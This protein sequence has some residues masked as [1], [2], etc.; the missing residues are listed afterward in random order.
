MKAIIDLI[1]YYK[2][3]YVTILY[4]E[5]TGIERIEDLV[6]MQREY[7]QQ[8]YSSNPYGQ[9]QPN[10][11]RIQVRQ[12]SK[13]VDK[14]IYLIKDVKLGSSSHI[15][16]DIQT[17]YLNDFLKQAEEVGLMTAYFH[18]IFTSL[19]IAILEHAP[20]ANI[21]A[22]QI[23]E[24]NDQNVKSLFA[25]F[26]LKNMVAHKPMFKYMPSEAVFIYDAFSLIANTIDRQNLAEVIPS[27]PSVSCAKEQPW[28]FGTDFLRSMKLSNFNGLSGHIE[29]DLVKGYRK[30]ITL[31]IVDKTKAGVDLIGYWRG[32]TEKGTIQIVRSYA[33]EKDRILDK[34]NRHLNVTTKLEAPY[35]MYKEPVNNETLVGNDRFKGYCVDLLDKISKI[36]GFNYTIKLV[37]DGL[38]GA[39]VDGKWNGLVS[40]LIEKVLSLSYCMIRFFFSIFI[41][42]LIQYRK[43]IWRWQR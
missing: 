41:T 23:Y 38:Y 3:E 34:L 33:K 32:N 39:F 9:N 31:S 10:K 28:F 27:A 11:L 5:T 15:I 30:N 18:F 14:W 6:R 42:A 19:D 22:L 12:L 26:N 35:V 36:C 16:V 8:P 1:E 17:K 7:G 24:P 2:W 21:T 40:E 25:E 29:F 37:E 4:Q 20:A 13:D 43:L